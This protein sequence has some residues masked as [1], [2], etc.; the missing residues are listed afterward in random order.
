MLG[1]SSAATHML[2]LSMSL[3]VFSGAGPGHQYLAESP[4]KL[5]C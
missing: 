1:L 3:N 4:P 2:N 5:Y